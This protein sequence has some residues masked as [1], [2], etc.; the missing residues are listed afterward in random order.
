MGDF[1][2][3][4]PPALDCERYVGGIT[5]QSIVDSM[6]M[7]L[8]TWMLTK[9]KLVPFGYPV[10][11]TSPGDGNTIFTSSKMA[12]YNL[13]VAN[14]K[15]VTPYLP[16][17]WSNEK[18]FVW[19]NKVDEGVSHGLPSGQIDHDLWGLKFPFPGTTPPVNDEIYTEIF[20]HETNK[21]Y[22]GTLKER[23]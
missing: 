18:Y 19:Q 22:C 8:T 5:N 21:V 6:G 11:Y 9:P 23:C 10:I 7:N 3:D 12:R 17:V 13:W 1:D 16:R 20:I 14:W 15:V 4:L 2:F